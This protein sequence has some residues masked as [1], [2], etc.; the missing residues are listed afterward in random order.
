[1]TAWTIAHQA[2]L[3]Q[4]FFKQ[5]YWNGLPFPNPGD[6]PDPEIETVSPVSPV[7][8]LADGFLHHTKVVKNTLSR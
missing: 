2:L 7:L 4:E 5:E 8:A 1:M 3:F 6:P